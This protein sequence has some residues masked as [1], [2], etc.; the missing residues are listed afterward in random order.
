MIPSSS[1]N[2]ISFIDNS[3]IKG[4]ENLY[5]EA[6]YPIRQRSKGVVSVCLELAS[7]GFKV[8]LYTNSKEIKRLAEMQECKEITVNLVEPRQ[9]E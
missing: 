6:S 1:A 5:V 9:A 3:F 8:N 4:K 7:K 2:G